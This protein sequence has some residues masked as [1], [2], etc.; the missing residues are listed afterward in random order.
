MN[1][2]VLAQ[3]GYVDGMNVQA[4][5]FAAPSNDLSSGAIPITSLPFTAIIETTE[6]TTDAE[7]TQLN[8]FCGAPALDASVWYTFVAPSDGVVVVDVSS[9]DYTAGVLVGTGTPGSLNIEACGPSTVGFFAFTGTTYYILVIDDQFDGGGNGG[10]LSFFM[11]Y[12]Q[13]PVLTEF[14]VNKRGTVDKLGNAQISGT[15]ACTNGDILEVDVEARQ[16]VGRVNTIQGFGFF[17]DIAACDGTTKS[18]S[19]TVPPNSGKFAGGKALTVSYSYVCGIFD[20][21]FGYVDQKVQLSKG[22][23]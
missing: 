9:S 1:L 22:G 7:D 13:S 14:T 16:A 10:T 23:K 8:E 2:R 20:C 5:D 3:D 6:A 18:W 12:V 19:V 21:A 15:Y 17:F 11:D 4:R